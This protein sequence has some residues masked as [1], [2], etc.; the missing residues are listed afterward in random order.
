M[1]RINLLP[2]REAR[3]KAVLR[4]Q[5]VLLGCALGLGLV[6]A[7]GLHLTV[8]ARISST[9]GQIAE[10]ESEFKR[11]EATLKKIE[12]YQQRKEEIQRKL[13]VISELEQARQGP[14]RILDEI[15]TRIPERM[16]LTSLSLKAGVLDMKGFG[17]DNE[18]IAAFMT[19]LGESEFVTDVALVET[20]LEEKKGLKLNSFTIRSRDARTLQV[21]SA[22]GATQ[23]R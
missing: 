14:V 2:V 17:L 7:L 15:A 20:N 4:Q 19:S 22:N 18:I 6:V 13:A 3:R 12:A 21:A 23:G 5:G 1:I 10:T 9:R 16:W 11:L 8:Q